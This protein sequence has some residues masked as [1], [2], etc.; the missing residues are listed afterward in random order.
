MAS[1]HSERYN[2]EAFWHKLRTYARSIGRKLMEKVLV[3]Y[4]LLNDPQVPRWAKGIAAAA[5][6]YFVLPIDAIPDL[7]PFAGYADDLGAI[8]AALAVLA[9]S[10]RRRHRD[11]ARAKVEAWFGPTG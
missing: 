9:A 1:D 6:G 11:Q 2:H 4:Y 8:T 10:L 5:L 3:L 7:V